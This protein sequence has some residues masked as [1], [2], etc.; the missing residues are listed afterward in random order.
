MFFFIFMMLTVNDLSAKELKCVRRKPAGQIKKFTNTMVPIL[1]K[2]NQQIK[3]S[4]P[5]VAQN[6][7]A[8]GPKNATNK[9]PK[10]P[11][12]DQ[13]YSS[14]KKLNVPTS[15]EM[16]KFIDSK[17]NSGDALNTANVNGVEFKDESPALI[18]AFRQL[19]TSRD[20]FGSHEDP[21]NQKDIQ[22]SYQINPSCNKVE[23]A[24]EKI[25]GEMGT[26]ILYIN[27][28]HKFNASELAF[29]ESSR[30]V[31]NELDDILLSLE[32]LPPFFIPLGANNQRLTH[33]TRGALPFGYSK[34]DISNAFIMVFDTWSNQ[35]PDSRRSSVFHEFAH[36]ISS[37]GNRMDLDPNW[38]KKSKWIKKG[39]DWS[40][41]ANAC[42]VSR[43]ASTQPAEDWAESMEAYR[44]ESKKF[45]ANCPEKY[46]Y[47]KELVF[48]NIEYTSPEAC[49]A[50]NTAPT[51]PITQDVPKKEVETVKEVAKETAPLT[52][53]APIAVPPE[54]GPSVVTT[55]P[56]PDPTPLPSEMPLENTPVPTPPSS[57][58]PLENTPAPTPPPSEKPLEE[59]PRAEESKSANE[60][61]K[62]AA[63]FQNGLIKLENETADKKDDS[64]TKSWIR[65]EEE[66]K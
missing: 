8:A 28:R 34:R 37:Q 18:E 41:G 6:K 50:A 62:D 66:L 2:Y 44:Y 65:E 1:S 29:D 24:V 38:L 7:K 20:I 52:P 35:R 27:L 17:K 21:A 36:N 58:V 16:K 40:H 49:S 32:D 30:F 59:T 45:K 31:K 10:S 33:Y 3:K 53:A 60:E 42:F 48:K 26:K 43:Y 11:P 13:I 56:V 19:T 63:D 61:A 14:C 22:K 55:T 9:I 51:N 64:I 23:C 54:E 46:N 4:K 5:S 15:E 12:D 47:L 39:D 25:W 57:E